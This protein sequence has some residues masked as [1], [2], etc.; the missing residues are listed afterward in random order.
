MILPS[1]VGRHAALRQH[2]AEPRDR[3][4]RARLVH[5][6]RRPPRRGIGRGVAGDAIGAHMQ[7]MRALAA[8]HRRDRGR[9]R[10]VDRHHVVAVDRDR[11]DAERLGALGHARPRR[12]ALGAREGRDAVVLAHEQHRQL[13]EHGP[14]Q[15]FEERPAIDRAVAEHAGHDRVGLL[16]LQALRGADR[17][18]DAAGDH[19]VRAEHAD[20]KVRDVHRAALAAAIAARPAVK[21][22]HHALRLGALGDRVAVAAMVRGDAVV[23]AQIGADAGRDPLLPDRDMQ[24]PGD[25]A[26]LVRLER[27]LLEGADAHHRAIK[28]G[29]AAQIV[30]WIA[31]EGLVGGAACAGWRGHVSTRRRKLN[32]TSTRRKPE[33]Q[34]ADTPHARSAHPRQ[35]HASFRPMRA[36]AP[37]LRP[38]MA[39]FMRRIWRRRRA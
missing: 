36:D 20:G 10:I 23:L 31:H 12:D 16:H 37:R 28:A 34:Q 30:A 25:F 21:L 6:V 5:F 14:V 29:E 39:A 27:G 11:R 4:A 18:R 33:D 8:P 35:R 3:I 19:A 9:R 7:E 22:Q 13:V 1:S 17:D 38:R 32:R 15:P 24:R 26:G 2:G